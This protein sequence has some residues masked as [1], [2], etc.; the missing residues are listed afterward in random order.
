M[1]VRFKQMW[2]EHK[3]KDKKPK[4]VIKDDIAKPL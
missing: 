2:I 1:K 3:S 4:D